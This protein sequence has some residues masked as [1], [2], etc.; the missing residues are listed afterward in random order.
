MKTLLTVLLFFVTINAWAVGSKNNIGFTQ[1]R[2]YDSPTF[3]YPNP[4]SSAIGISFTLPSA[5]PTSKLFIREDIIVAN[6]DPNQL[7]RLYVDSALTIPLA[8]QPIDV[9]SFGDEQTRTV[10]VYAKYYSTSGNAVSRAGSY[11][12]QIPIYVTDATEEYA[13]T[14]EFYPTVEGSCG[15]SQASYNVSTNVGMSQ[16]AKTS[17]NVIYN[18]SPG[19]TPSMTSD[20][21]SFT[22]AEDNDMTMQ[23]FSDNSYSRNIAN[24]PLELQADGTNKSQTLYLQHFENGSPIISKAGTYNFASAIIINF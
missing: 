16:V 13:A 23:I 5:N 12:F 9:S 19:L 3:S 1:S 24:E 20:S 21:A 14:I 10:E 15:F 22:S 17:T 2:F 18:C 6:E 4:Y 7:V 8:S 11:S